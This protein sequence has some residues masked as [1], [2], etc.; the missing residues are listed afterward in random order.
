MIVLYYREKQTRN[1]FNSTASYFLTCTTIQYIQAV[2]GYQINMDLTLEE[3]LKE[4]IL[5]CISYM[6]EQIQNPQ[7]VHG[8]VHETRRTIK[9]IRA[10]LRMI[11]DEIGYYNYNIENTCYRELSG[12]LSSLRDS[13]VLLETVKDLNKRFPE[14]FPDKVTMDINDSLQLTIEGGLDQFFNQWGGFDRMIGELDEARSRVDDYC[15]LRDEFSSIRKGIQ[16][17]Y[18]RGSRYLR[19]ILKEY[20]K[21][22]F[23]EYRKNAKYLLHHM[24]LLMPV[25]PKLI[26]ASIRTNDKHVELLG[27]I[28][29]F[30]QLER[31]I[32]NGVEN[33]TF[34][35]VSKRLIYSIHAQREELTQKA[36]SKANRIYAE[37]PSG[38]INGLANYWDNAYLT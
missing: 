2:K 10:V 29:D 9:R 34:N 35:A 33:K 4:V 13:F 23:H 25:N 32:W 20:N 1:L 37:K 16:R 19:I 22:Q 12:R 17:I 15:R 8:P 26:K 24:E 11:R 18:K 3:S 7:E 21:E 31:Y 6:Q 30:E 27:D 38:F 36:L 5:K 14:E 28:R